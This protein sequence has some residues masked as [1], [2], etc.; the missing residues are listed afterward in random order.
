MLQVAEKTSNRYSL[1]EHIEQ[2][3]VTF[4]IG[5]LT[6]SYATNVERMILWGSGSFPTSVCITSSTNGTDY[7]YLPLAIST[8]AEPYF[9]GEQ[10]KIMMA[11]F[12]TLQTQ[13]VF[14][15]EKSQQ[16]ELALAGITSRLEELKTLHANWNGEEAEK[17]DP[18]AVD[19]AI[20]LV[21]LMYLAAQ[22]VGEWKEP[23]TITA[24]TYGRVFLAWLYGYGKAMR[25]ISIY[26]A[27][28]SISCIRTWGQSADAKIDGIPVILD[29][30]ILREMVWKWLI[31][32]PTAMVR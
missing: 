20:S 21:N 6:P 9:L 10:L 1:V 26:V 30:D 4:D 14:F 31:E 25:G 27:S 23:G 7:G 8:G 13:A 5:H 16:Q 12:S 32:S 18:G 17:P 11:A 2:D 28:N 29:K 3:K 15:D 24:D 22:E 19:R